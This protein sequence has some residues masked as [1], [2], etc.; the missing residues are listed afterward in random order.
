MITIK[1]VSV[2]YETTVAVNNVSL[3]IKQ[4]SMIG[5][6]G[7]NGA[8]KSSLL[9]ALAGLI[10]DFTGR[11]AFDGKD[12]RGE[13]FWV[14]Q[15]CGYAPEDA[16]LLPYLRGREFLHLIAAIR[17]VRDIQKEADFFI[18]LFSLQKTAEELIV[19][20]SH[21]MRQKLSIAA[22]LIGQPQWLI[23]DEALNGLDPLSLA[24]LKNYFAGQQSKGTT[25]VLSSHNLSLIRRWCE[26][27][28]FLHKGKIVG[29]FSQGEIKAQE[30]QSGRTFEDWF[31]DRVTE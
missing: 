2:R 12:L 9:K 31:V 29:V 15:H 26:A 19:N 3:N 11:V 22:A 23:L 25:I 7:A 18:D 20:Y 1:N 10:P 28:V 16:E 6:I 14:K 27:V 4:G 24:R 21:G 8:G 17:K 30:E 13:R 5:L